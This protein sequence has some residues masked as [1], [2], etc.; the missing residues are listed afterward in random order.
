MSSLKP[1]HII[2]AIRDL[3]SPGTD[4]YGQAYCWGCPY[5]D[6]EYGEKNLEWP[7]PTA[8]LVY[9]PEEIAEVEEA[10]TLEYRWNKSMRSRNPSFGPHKSIWELLAPEKYLA[11]VVFPKVPVAHTEIKYAYVPV[12]R[13]LL[14]D[15]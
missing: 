6:S 4:T 8:R 7:C 15:T 13:Q 12:S 10:A 9:S 14:E 2:V 5:D 1:E 3:H 11:D